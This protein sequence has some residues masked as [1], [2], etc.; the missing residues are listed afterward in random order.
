MGD[1]L[2]VGQEE[3]LDETP[4][5]KLLDF[6]LK[7]GHITQL[8]SDAR[9]IFNPTFNLDC[10]LQD[11]KMSLEKEFKDFKQVTKG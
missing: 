6:L 4:S 2:L 5:E 11:L 9:E 8:F 3:I 7:A 10:L 1:K